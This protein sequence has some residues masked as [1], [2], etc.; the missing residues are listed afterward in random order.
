MTDADPIWITEADVVG[1]IDLADAVDAVEA[2]LRLQHAGG[3]ETM[4]KTHLLWGDGHTLHA[5]G[6]VA[7]GRELAATKTWAHTGGGA[8]PLLVIWSTESGRLLAIIEAFA[9]GQ[10][11]T[12]SMSGVATRWLARDGA[13]TMAIIGTGKQ[14]LAQVAAVAAVRPLHAVNVHSPTK[15][16]R[17]AFVRKLCEVRPDLDVRSADTVAEASAAADVVTT[18]SR[19]RQPFLDASM[20]RA[21]AHINAVGAI[22]PERAE[23]DADLVEKAGVVVVDSEP[24]ARRLAREVRGVDRLVPLSEVV[25][26]DDARD[27]AD[28]TVFKAMGIGLADLALGAEILDRA[29]ARGAGRPVPHPERAAP[30]LWRSSP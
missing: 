30:R 29:R 5:I 25:D 6:A 23:L 21:G 24:A 8:T 19:A 17:D 20:V 22:S 3:A 4:D 14:A 28:L 11:R 10:M 16:H 7:E 18:V 26:R 2:M 9:L 12:G 15:D 13:S 1:L 27:G